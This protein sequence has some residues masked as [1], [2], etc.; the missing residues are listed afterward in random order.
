MKSAEDR[1]SDPRRNLIS[2]SLPHLLDAGYFLLAAGFSLLS[3]A[4]FPAAHP[5]FPALVLLISALALLPARNWIRR[6]M[7]NPPPGRPLPVAG[8]A[9]VEVLEDGAL[10]LLASHSPGEKAPRKDSGAAAPADSR[11]LLLNLSQMLHSTSDLDVLLELLSS[12]TLRLVPAS[13][14]RIALAEEHGAL[15]YA[16]YFENGIRRPDREAIPFP[17]EDDL[18][19]EVVRTGRPLVPADYSEACRIRNLPGRESASAWAGFPLPAGASISGAMLLLRDAPFA[20]NERALLESI[21]AAAGPAIAGARLELGSARRAALLTSLVRAS[22]RIVGAAERDSLPDA[23]LAEAR[24]LLPCQSALLLLPT[25][26]GSWSVETTSGGPGASAA[27]GPIESDHPLLK[28]SADDR[29]AFLDRLPADDPFRREERRAGPE[30]SGALSLALRRREKTIGWVIFWNPLRP[31]P[32]PEWEAMLL[33]EFAAVCAAALRKSRPGSPEGGSAVARMEELA[34]LQ[35][36]DQELN[37]AADPAAAMAV[38]L[39]WAMRYAEAAAGLAAICAD[40]SL[41]VSAA[42][43]YPPGAGPEAG[44]RFP[45]E[46]AGFS[47]SI[48]SGRAH[49]RRAEGSAAPGIFPSGRASLFLPI[50]RNTQTL[51]VL[52]LESGYADSF[53]PTEVEFLERLAAHAAI[54]ISSAQLY[55]EVRNA[56]QAKSEFISF[57]A[58]ELKTPMTSIRGYTDLLAQGAV[59]P[60]SQPQAN[61]LATIRLNVDRMAAL[62]SDLNDVSRI[63]SG[64]LK[65]EFS[66]VPLAP[67]LH[68]VVEALRS[69]IEG[70]EQKLTVEIPDDLPPAWVDRGRLIQIL[71]NLVSNAHKYTPGGGS[72]RISAERCSNRWDPAGPPE[73]VHFLI[74][75]SGLGISLQEQK[76]IFQKFF[77]SEDGTVR[78]LPG[79]GLGLHITRNLVEMHGGRIWFESELHKGSTFHFTVPAASV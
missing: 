52:L 57:V 53:K 11:D 39:D 70:K 71:T 66:A 79:T 18:A 61:F 2:G 68:E 74:Q 50:R 47:E 34:S 44:V 29:P 42:S 10:A 64:R 13:S 31:C 30:F 67:V 35:H 43:G 7:P 24:G 55:A 40:E 60:V 1:R 8:S 20:E 16:Y 78:D 38:T 17:G 5:L 21:A 36:L 26:S 6:R 15:T 14:F 65:L 58:H 4:A 56:N 72:L 62:V 32:T 37:N 12:Q 54:A 77:R 69:Q 63:E 49:L 48:Q 76:S 28:P 9:G 59:G 23:I 22:R 41:E 45:R 73:I 27:F 46:S 19:G 33:S 75:D 25:P 51:G 3:Y